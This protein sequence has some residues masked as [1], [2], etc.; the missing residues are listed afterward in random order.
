MDNELYNQISELLQVV[1]E[2]DAQVAALESRVESLSALLDIAVPLDPRPT[3]TPKKTSE[4]QQAKLEFYKDY[5]D[6]PEVQEQIE[7]FKKTF[8]QIKKPPWQFVKAVTDAMMKSD[9]DF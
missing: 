8:P 1:S 9:D 2:K 5:K 6:S 4:R 7:L 3:S